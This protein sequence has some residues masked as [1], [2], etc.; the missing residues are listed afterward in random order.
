ME[1]QIPNCP[2]CGAILK[3]HPDKN[4]WCC[5]NWKK[6]NA[7]CEG[8]IYFPSKERKKNY[9][10]VTFSIK[11]ESKSNPGHFHQVKIYETGDIDCP[12]IASGMGKFCRHKRM[13]VENIEKLLEKIKK[14]N[15]YATDNFRHIASQ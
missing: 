6:D 3:K 4:Y 1:N 14:E 10:N 7:G 13:T 12:C 2:H 5:P 11:I 15:N 8:T 9:P